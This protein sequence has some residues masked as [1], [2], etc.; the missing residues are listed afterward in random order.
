MD[1]FCHRSGIVLASQ[2]GRRD[3]HTELRQ[4]FDAAMAG[5]FGCEAV[6]VVSHM[7]GRSTIKLIEVESG[8]DFPHISISQYLNISGFGATFLENYF[9]QR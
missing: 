2:H 4:V 6:L 3:W 9:I 7:Q 5:R 8:A 1:N